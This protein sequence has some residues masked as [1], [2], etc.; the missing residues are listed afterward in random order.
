MARD[1]LNL[2]EVNA[3]NLLLGTALWG[4]RVAEGAAFEML[5]TFEASGGTYVDTA[6]NYPINAQPHDHGRALKILSSWFHAHPHSH[7]RMM[8]KL[9]SVSNDGGSECRV[10]G[11]SLRTQSSRLLDEFGSAIAGIAIHWDTRRGDDRASRDAIDST[12]RALRDLDQHGLRVGFS[13]LADPAT[14]LALA[15]ELAERWWIQVKENIL[16]SAAR[17]RYAPHFPDAIYLAYGIN[18]GGVSSAE[19]PRMGSSVALRR[20]P[21]GQDVVAR[22][23]EGYRE[24]GV[25]G[26]RED[27][28]TVLAVRHAHSNPA[29]AGIVA[30]PSSTS[31][32][33]ETL[34]S[35]KVLNG[36]A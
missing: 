21:H 16:D 22:M 27:P 15:P 1:V 13:G 36:G 35:W 17:D 14:Y 34:E 9:G 7:L 12:V 30:G 23:R 19:P 18:L 2:F 28:L 26:H 3:K 8:V 24:A 32:L 4:W 10:D 5:E 25:Q 33:K 31:Q 20:V 29:L 11:D 6:T